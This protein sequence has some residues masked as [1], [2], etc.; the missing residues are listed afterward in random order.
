MT[1]TTLAAVGGHEEGHDMAKVPNTISDADWAELRRR[2]EKVQPP[3]FSD[4]AIR[5][6][7]AASAQARNA[8]L[9]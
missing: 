5:G 8:R 3:F 6:R 9:N 7:K 1:T 2:R 4:E